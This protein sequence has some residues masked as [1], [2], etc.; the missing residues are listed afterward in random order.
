M[1]AALSG[2]TS[3]ML[4]SAVE[5]AGGAKETFIRTKP[6]CN[7]GTIGDDSERTDA[8]AI[9]TETADGG[10][11][12]GGPGGF[13]PDG[14]DGDLGGFKN[15][16]P[17]IPEYPDPTAEL[18][19]G[20][21]RIQAT[22]DFDIISVWMNGSDVEVLI[23]ENVGGLPGAVVLADSFPADQ[24][25]ELRIYALA[26]A[27]IIVNDTSIPD[28]IWCGLN[29]DDVTCGHGDSIVFSQ[30]G[31]SIVRGRGGDDILLGDDDTNYLFGGD[32]ADYVEGFDGVDVVSGGYADGTSDD[33]VDLL[34]GGA[35]TDYFVDPRQATRPTSWTTSTRPKTTTG[36]ERSNVWLGRNSVFSQQDRL[37]S[38]GRTRRTRRV[39]PQL[40]AV[41]IRTATVS[42]PSRA[43]G[44]IRHFKR[45]TSPVCVQ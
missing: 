40:I 11:G 35:D 33:V 27:D 37:D 1:F 20:T 34:I 18:S 2:V 25:S 4:A 43:V 9:D 12:G 39:R 29:I 10:V 7:V 24:V 42:R 13:Q 32:G 8:Y 41:C 30:S 45:R 5:A 26:G 31:G 6:H 19:E 28:I 21:L 16:G 23:E 14:T 15:P 38:W 17:D 36:R 22:Q 44:T 3:L